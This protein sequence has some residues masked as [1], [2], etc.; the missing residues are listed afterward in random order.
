MDI[1]NLS[2]ENA[3]QRKW[4]V[5]RLQI[6]SG[7]SLDEIYLDYDYKEIMTFDDFK[8]LCYS[9]Y[10]IDKENPGRYEVHHPAKPPLKH[11][12]NLEF[13]DPNNSNTN[14][15]KVIFLILSIVILLFTGSLFFY[16][17]Y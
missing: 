13:Y 6:E 16:F 7:K 15:R 12:T 9:Q 5:I 1:K 4:E 14:S 8:S 2:P 10:L 3:I 17:F 11:K